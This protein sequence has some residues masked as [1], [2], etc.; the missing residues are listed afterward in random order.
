MFP[1]FSKG[2]RSDKIS[3]ERK[4]KLKQLC[5]VFGIKIHNFELLDKALTHTSYIDRGSE[6]SETYERLEFL[7]DSILNASVAYILFNS[8]PDLREGGLSSFRS[9]I[10]DEKTLSEIALS[11]HITDYI[12]LGKGETLSDF[13]A[14]VKVAAD[15]LESIIGVVFLEKGF[16]T[17]LKFVEQLMDKVIENRLKSG[18][19]DFKTQLQK[20]TILFYK[21]Y[22]KYEIVKEHGPDHNKI[23]EV[24]VTVHKQYSASGA[25]RTKKEAEQKAAQKVLLEI[26]QKHPDLDKPRKKTKQESV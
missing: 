13:R 24:K 12:N 6:Y 26:R 8:N 10:V 16:P 19:R 14:R 15:I 5:K 18:T 3:P 25:G 4:K 21:E 11:Y 23:F 9:S 20:W 17:A 7:G 1:L 2:V 22:P